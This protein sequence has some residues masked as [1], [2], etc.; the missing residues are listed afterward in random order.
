MV[1]AG[2]VRAGDVAARWS[3][4]GARD[5][6]APALINSRTMKRTRTDEVCACERTRCLQSARARA[7]VGG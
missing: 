1:V 6:R 3:L 5:T 2:R 7:R 4:K